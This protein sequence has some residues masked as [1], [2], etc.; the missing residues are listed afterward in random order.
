M[1]RLFFDTNVLLDVLEKRS[2]W[3]PESAECLARVRRGH[4]VG[5]LSALSLSDI[6]YIQKSAS[7][8]KLYESFRL[9]REFLDIAPLDPDTV[10]ATLARQLPDIEDGFQLEAALKWKATHLLTR[11]VKDFPLDGSIIIQTPAEYLQ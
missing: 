7:T 8:A 5:A 4:C 6:S 10:D 3:F 2:P 11:N 9:L 1:D